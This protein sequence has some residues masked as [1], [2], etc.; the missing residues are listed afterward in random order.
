M[1]LPQTVPACS[2]PSDTRLL[3]LLLALSQVRGRGGTT[4][5]IC[6]LAQ[7]PAQVPAQAPM[8]P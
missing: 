5:T 3:L 6:M 2:C 7:M 1:P 8:S 4:L